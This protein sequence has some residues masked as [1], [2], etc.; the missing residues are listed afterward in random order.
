M[1][2][3]IQDVSKAILDGLQEKYL[4][5]PTREQWEVIADNYQHAW[6]LPNCLGALD[7]KHI[8]LRCP[9]HSGSLYYNY[10]K[11][12][13]VVLMAAC[14][15]FGRFTWLNCG[16]YGNLMKHAIIEKFVKQKLSRGV[17]SA[18]LALLV[19]NFGVL[20]NQS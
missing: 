8:R 14:D 19:I 6:K 4:E 12:Y 18:T 7:G 3:I 9:P 1:Y 10:N 17:K 11:F 13:S 15:A 5:F 20:F 16:N 2:R